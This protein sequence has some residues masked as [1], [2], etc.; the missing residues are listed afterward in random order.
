VEQNRLSHAGEFGKKGG[1]NFPWHAATRTVLLE[2]TFIQAPQFDVGAA[3]QA[4]EF[5]YCGDF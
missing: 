1:R 4:A 2:V 5:F 3:S